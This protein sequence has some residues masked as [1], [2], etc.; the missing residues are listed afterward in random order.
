ME[1]QNGK[2]KKNDIYDI[3]LIAATWK[4][5]L[6]L[7]LIPIDTSKII[8]TQCVHAFTAVS[9]KKIFLLSFQI[10]FPSFFSVAHVNQ[11]KYAC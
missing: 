5:L 6:I 10:S 7:L 4:G 1:F 2:S 8:G 9:C 3:L 11:I